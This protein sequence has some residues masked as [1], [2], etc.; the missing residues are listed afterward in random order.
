MCESK[1]F[2]MTWIKV[3]DWGFGV[4]IL[5]GY[6]NC[7]YGCRKGDQCWLTMVHRTVGRNPS[8]ALNP[9]SVASDPLLCRVIQK[10]NV[11]Y[12]TQSFSFNGDLY[13]YYNFKFFPLFF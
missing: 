4:I 12:K 3:W 9:L 10:I 8:H 1:G 2:N 6:C 13:L 7:F 11:G 5:L